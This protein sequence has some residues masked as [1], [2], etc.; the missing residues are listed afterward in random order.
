MMIG[1]NREP[2]WLFNSDYFKIMNTFV[3]GFGNGFL[4]TFLMMIGP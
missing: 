1:L 3:L 4:G 2:Y